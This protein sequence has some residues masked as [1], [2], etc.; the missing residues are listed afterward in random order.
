MARKAVPGRKRRGGWVQTA[1][2]HPARRRLSYGIASPRRGGSVA[3]PS[4]PF[5]RHLRAERRGPRPTIGA[6]G[7]GSAHRKAGAPDEGDLEEAF[8]KFA[9][10]WLAAIAAAAVVVGCVRRHEQ[11]RA[12]ILKIGDRVPAAGQ[13]SWPRPVRRATVRCWPSRRP[14]RAGT[15]GAT[16]SR[17]SSSDHAR[18][19]PVRRAAGRQG[20]ADVV[21]D[22]AVVGV[23]GPF[24]SAVAKVADPDRQRG[25]PDPVQ[26]GQHQPG[27]D[28]GRGRRARPAAKNPDKINYVRVATTDDIQGPAVAQYAYQDLGLKNVADHR[29]H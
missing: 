28:Q 25:R 4:S 29:R 21:A 23:I 10:R 9:R 1:T 8:M 16:R 12:R 13:L 18:Q 26:P 14:T 11:R 19:R 2:L 3:G 6:T 20:H 24:N 22:T 27:P 7:S 15:V 5:R 17:R